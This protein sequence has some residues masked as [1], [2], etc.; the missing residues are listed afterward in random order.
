MKRYKVKQ[1]IKM[2]DRLR[3]LNDI[4]NDVDLFFYP[5]AVMFGIGLACIV[6]PV[7]EGVNELVPL[8]FGSLVS[9]GSGASLA[10]LFSA[11]KLSDKL[12]E[13]LNK[14]YDF[15]G[16]EFKSKVQQERLKREYGYEEKGRS[17]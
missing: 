5:L 15:M 3:N 14:I 12:Y 10:Y 1:V 8:V 13:K 4:S 11:E 9:L 7:K 2:E 17:R 6:G 16:S